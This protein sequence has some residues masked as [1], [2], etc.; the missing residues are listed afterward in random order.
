MVSDG[1]K[2]K[3]KALKAQAPLQVRKRQRFAVCI[4]GTGFDLLA[5]RVYKVLDDRKAEQHGSVRV[6]DE[7]G[8]DYLYPS[9]WFIPVKPDK[10]AE[11]RLAAI[12]VSAPPADREAVIV[13]GNVRFIKPSRE[14]IRSTQFQQKLDS[15]KRQSR[16][17]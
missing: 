10:S 7:S 17:G 11:G 9:S 8:E 15:S 6:V 12:L 4:Q 14:K 16:K 3:L 1:K 13:R 2:S 5:H